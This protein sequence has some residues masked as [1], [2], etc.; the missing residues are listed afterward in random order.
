[1]KEKSASEDSLFCH[2]LA[3]VAGGIVFARVV[4]QSVSSP[5]SARLLLFYQAKTLR[6][7]TIPPATQASHNQDLILTESR[8]HIVIRDRLDRTTSTRL[9]TSTTF[10][11]RRISNRGCFQ[12]PHSFVLFISREG[13]SK[14]DVGN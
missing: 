13:A 14:N 4:F 3:C 2:N 6:A 10:E 7:R 5:F 9:N 8:R 12:S 1:M 11:F